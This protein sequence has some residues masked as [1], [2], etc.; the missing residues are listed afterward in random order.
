[1]QTHHD[2]IQNQPIQN[3]PIQNQ[4]IQEKSEI[5]IL[6]IIESPNTASAK[7]NKS[8]KSSKVDKEKVS[9]SEVKNETTDK[10]SSAQVQANEDENTDVVVKTKSNV[11]EEKLDDLFNKGIEAIKSQRHSDA[12]NYFNQFLDKAPKTHPNYNRAI[13]YR[14]RANSP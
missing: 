3:Q 14:D 11:K 12:L 13:L 8:E 7:K 6:K 4:P 2:Q 10:K 9:K 1:M 5:P